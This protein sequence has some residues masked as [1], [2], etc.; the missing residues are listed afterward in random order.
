MVM[1]SRHQLAH[2]GSTI[3]T[4]FGSTWGAGP[5]TMHVAPLAHEPVT[6]S[7]DGEATLVEVPQL[8]QCLFYA[9][10]T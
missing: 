7:S 3:G 6:S 4:T 9:C 1:W 8:W 2:W 10:D 5:G